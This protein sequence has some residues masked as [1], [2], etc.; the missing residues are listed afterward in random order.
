MLT[1]TF[2]FFLF[3][4]GG[5]GFCWLVGRDG[6]LEEHIRVRASVQ[7]FIVLDGWGQCELALG[8][9]PQSSHFPRVPIPG[10]ASRLRRAIIMANYRN[11]PCSESFFF[12]FIA[13]TSGNVDGGFVQAV[14]REVEKPSR[15]SCPVLRCGSC[16]WDAVSF[17]IGLVVD[18]VVFAVQSS[19]QW[20]GGVHSDTSCT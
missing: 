8:F 13:G 20:H 5:A 18:R 16:T 3:F 6:D 12:F 7:G 4:Q 2:F 17:R 15:M 1:T 14:S 9:W 19:C 10:R 11:S